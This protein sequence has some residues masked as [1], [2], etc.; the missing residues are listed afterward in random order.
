M[1][2]V[3]RIGRR[4]STALLIPA[5]ALGAALAAVA[6]L[7]LIV[8]APPGKALLT[9]LRGSLGDP[10]GIGYTLFYATDYVFA[11]LAVALPF[12]AGL[13]NIGGEGQAA[14]GGLGATLA[15][16]A[17][18]GAPPALILAAAALAAAGF[19][20]LWALV[21][22]WLQAWRGSHLVITTIMFNFIAAALMSWL[23][24]RVLIAPG[25]N[26]PET[27]EFSPALWLPTL[28][29]LG[30]RIGIDA[31]GA[32]LNPCALLAL[33]AAVFYWLLLRR[34]PLGYEIRAV[35]FNPSAARAAGIRVPRTQLV[36][37]CGGG[38]FAGLI[39]LN[40]LFGAQHRLNLDMSSGAGFTGIAVALMGRGHALGIVL[41][42]ILF[43]ALNQGGAALAFDVPNVTH[44]VVILAEGVAI[45]VCGAL[46]GAVRG[47]FG[48][49][50]QTLRRTPMRERA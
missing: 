47:H 36:A 35:G 26:A 28:A 19:A 7:V 18:R 31:G 10:E 38:A 44:D 22:A 30:A 39:A 12:Q 23:L 1:R 6:V 20:A 24:A 29:D 48:R 40:E 43:G 37:V 34:T 5:I 32:P 25:H 14:L 41:A 2:P 9:L 13:F 17:L 42:A 49:L 11:G 45:F 46:D 21:P 8:G 3:S 4:L 15:V 27:R 16:F 50:L 33:I